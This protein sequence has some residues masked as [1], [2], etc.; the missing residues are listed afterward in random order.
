VDRDGLRQHLEAHG[1]ATGIHYPIPIHLPPAWRALG[2]AAGVLP[3]TERL[4]AEIV[5]LPMPPFLSEFDVK[6]AGGVHKSC[7]GLTERRPVDGV[8]ERSS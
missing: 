1:V 2:T 5:P 8:A 4:A 3:I 6:Y 7:P